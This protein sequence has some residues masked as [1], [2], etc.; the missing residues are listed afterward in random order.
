MDGLITLIF[1]IAIITKIAKKSEQKKK[2]QTRPVQNT[3]RREYPTY[4]GTG[5]SA[6]TVARQ[7]P[8]Q[9]YGNPTYGNSTYA[10][11]QRSTS[12]DDLKSRLQQK[13]GQQPAKKTDILTKAKKNTNEEAEDVIAHVMRDE[14]H[15]S[16]CHAPEVVMDSVAD[17]Q[18]EESNILGS[19]NELMVKGYSGNLEFERDFIAEGVEMLNR[20]SL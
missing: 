4:K 1:F 2:S 5:Q 10:R 15:A 13:Y 6:T 18:V 16:E 7:N 20:F 17:F 9:T 12:Q 19:V 14:A 3:Q 8:N 11:Q